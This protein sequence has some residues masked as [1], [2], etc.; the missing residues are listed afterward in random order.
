M[1]TEMLNEILE[2]VS[3]VCE[4]SREELLSH[5][6]REDVIDARCIFI[7]HCMTYGFKKQVL[8]DFLDRKRRCVIDAYIRNYPYFYKQSYLF[9][10]YDQQISDKLSG[11]YPVSLS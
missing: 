2:V 1:K 10:L 7:H 8:A 5:C 9:R 4:V 11:K 3:N 6:K